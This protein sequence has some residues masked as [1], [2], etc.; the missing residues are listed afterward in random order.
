MMTT[1]TFFTCCLLLSLVFCSCFLSVDSSITQKLQEDQWYSAIYDANQGKWL[2]EKGKSDNAAAVGKFSDSS[3]TGWNRLWII[4]SDKSERFTEQQVSQA[5]GYLEG[6]LS[7]NVIHEYWDN[8][9][10]I[11]N[12]S[13]FHN[14]DIRSKVV[15]FLST[16]QNWVKS[17]VAS[18]PNSLIWN[19][20]GLMQDQLEGMF[21]G[22]NAYI[23]DNNKQLSF[24]D[25][26]FLNS[27]PDILDL[28]NLVS[29][30]SR[31]PWFDLT[32]EQA[33]RKFHETTHCSALIKPVNGDNSELYAGHSTWIFF[34]MMVR[35]FKF[36]QT[37][38]KNVRGIRVA[39]SSFPGQLASADDYYTIS[40]GLMV[41]E[42]SNSI[43]NTSLYSSVTPQSLLSWQR[44]VLANRLAS[45][46][47]EWAK[48]FAVYNSG[49]YNNQWMVLDYKRYEADKMMSG[50]LWIVE[51]IPGQVESGDQTS[52]LQKQGYWPSYN[53]PF[54]PAIFNLSGYPQ[55][56]KQYGDS[57]SYQNCP[58]AK[59]FRRNETQVFSIEDMKSLMRYNNYENDPLSLG[60][61]GNAIASRFDL[62]TSNPTPMGAIDSKVTS[63]T[64]IR[65]LIS[66]AISGPTTQQ[67]DAFTWTE[68]NFVSTWPHEGQPMT[69]NYKWQTM[70]FE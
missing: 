45:N 34:S 12:Q 5:I 40:S 59:I 16:Q 32:E 49:T 48:F 2:L 29:P 14:N 44:T 19:Q 69:W 3:N 57:F 38:F 54:Y 64:R 11:S 46:G 15:D 62:A 31:I 24:L 63:S 35:V 1:K 7:C 27:F 37:P 51:Q 17:M 52:I 68:H 65:H 25:L 55:M 6:A 50:L 61:P 22:Y 10:I 58:R 18:N 53:I 30:E 43:F 26:V 33:I 13:F 66:E 41:T 4:G 70:S 56:V 47:A 42:T 23:N 28:I 9:N 20:I 60:D 67:Q 39:F 8:I 21:A 36:I